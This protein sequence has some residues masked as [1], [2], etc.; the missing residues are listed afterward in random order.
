MGIFAFWSENVLKLK[1]NALSG[2]QNT[3]RMSREENK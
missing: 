3:P 2:T 1:L